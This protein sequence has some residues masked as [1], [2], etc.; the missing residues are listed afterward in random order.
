MIEDGCDPC[1]GL[2][3]AYFGDEEWA[4]FTKKHQ[5][6]K[7]TQQNVAQ[8]RK[9][10]TDKTAE[11]PFWAEGVESCDD[12]GVFVWGRGFMLKT[13]KELMAEMSKNKITKQM[14]VGV[15]TCKLRAEDGSG[16]TEVNYMYKDPRRQYR[17]VVPFVK[18][19]QSK[20][21][22][23]MDP[24]DHVWEGQSNKVFNFAHRAMLENAGLEKLTS[25]TAGKEA[26]DYCD[27]L[28]HN[29]VEI[30]DYLSDFVDAPESAAS[31]SQSGD[32]TGPGPSPGA[33]G[34]DLLKSVINVEDSQAAGGGDDEVSAR[35]SLCEVM[36]N[37]PQADEK[38]PKKGGQGKKKKETI[39]PAK[40]VVEGDDLVKIGMGEEDDAFS[41]AGTDKTGGFERCIY[42]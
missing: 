10:S 41:L 17:T 23:L 33:I 42:K 39:A 15:P 13:E 7:V 1:V 31:G 28:K 29:G 4:A 2:W 24:N 21:R 22:A 3:F 30:P 11:R 32:N 6:D 18:I 40:D 16:N 19:S 37:S 5:T 25:L 14:L 38:Q 26:P 27:F 12:G 9:H 35:P 34:D 20:S 8:A 36:K